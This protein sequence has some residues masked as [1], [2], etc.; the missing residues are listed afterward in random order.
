MDPSVHVDMML[1]KCLCGEKAIAGKGAAK[2]CRAAWAAGAWDNVV[3][4]SEMVT[5]F[6][7]PAWIVLSHCDS[8]LSWPK[9]RWNFNCVADALWKLA[10][11]SGEWDKAAQLSFDGMDSCW[12]AV[13]MLSPDTQG[14]W[15]EVGDESASAYARL[16]ESYVRWL[17]EMEA[18][19]SFLTHD[20]LRDPEL[21][22]DLAW[23]YMIARCVNAL[24]VAFRVNDIYERY[25]GSVSAALLA[26]SMIERCG[27]RFR[28]RAEYTQS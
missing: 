17:P 7:Q 5:F 25:D 8:R 28:L 2:I 6:D 12:F 14:L 10:D 23:A 15:R 21:K 20:D 4:Q 18:L 9:E 16:L 19:K 13:A 11:K 1:P 22:L 24:G 3:P 27:E 26:M